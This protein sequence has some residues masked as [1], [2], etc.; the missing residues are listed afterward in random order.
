MLYQIFPVWTLLCGFW[1]RNGNFKWKIFIIF[2]KSFNTSVIHVGSSKP[3]NVDAECGLVLRLYEIEIHLLI[4]F[5]HN[6]KIISKTPYYMWFECRRRY[7]KKKHRKNIKICLHLSHKTKLLLLL[8]FVSVKH[9]PHH[10]KKKITS[11]S[12]TT[13]CTIYMYCTHRGDT[14]KLLIILLDYFSIFFIFEKKSR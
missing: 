3:I 5:L 13:R 14:H 12:Y 6:I 4:I 8:I 10:E 11:T 1:R 2:V 9:S 7:T